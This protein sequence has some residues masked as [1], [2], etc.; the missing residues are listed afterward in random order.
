MGLR[1]SIEEIEAEAKKIIEE[2]QKEAERILEEARQE[3]ERWK[4]M[5]IGEPLTKEEVEK[6]KREFQEKIS[7]AENEYEERRKAIVEAFKL[8]KE[9]LVNELVRLVTATGD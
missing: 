4:T 1:V 9:G 3:A 6:I 5:P 8:K 7:Q 2:A